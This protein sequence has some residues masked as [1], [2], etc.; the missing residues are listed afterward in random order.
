MVTDI[1]N[2]L[3]GRPMSKIKIETNKA[4]IEDFDG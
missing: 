3:P 2:A 1:I 4:S